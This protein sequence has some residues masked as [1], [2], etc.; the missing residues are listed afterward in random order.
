VENVAEIKKKSRKKKFLPP[1][2][3]VPKQ[4][5]DKVLGKLIGS[6]PQ[7]RSPV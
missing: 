5:F 6:K 2:V 1:K 3:K 7:K 4:D